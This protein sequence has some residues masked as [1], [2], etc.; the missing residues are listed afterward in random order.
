MQESPHRRLPGA[1]E[2]L[3]SSREV[4]MVEKIDTLDELGF[5]DRLSSDGLVVEKM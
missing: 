1:D 5:D 4:K 2:I 3:T